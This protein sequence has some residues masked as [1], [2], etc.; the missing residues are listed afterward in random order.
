MIEINDAMPFL[1][2]EI[3][4]YQAK[5]NELLS[6]ILQQGITEGLFRSVEMEPIIESFK[7]IIVAIGFPF[8]PLL[9][10]REKK[11]VFKKIDT[12]LDLIING[13]KK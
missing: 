7:D 10:Q 4:T 1:K 5:T 11:L 13:L 3:D 8:S 2:R 12:M 6:R 9:L